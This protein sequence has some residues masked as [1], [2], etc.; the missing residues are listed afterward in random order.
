M[1]QLHFPRRQLGVGG[2]GAICPSLPCVR[3]LRA[4][5][6][7]VIGARV[8][9][10]A[11]VSKLRIPTWQDCSAAAVLG[12]VTVL[13][14]PL[15]CSGHKEAGGKGFWRT[16]EGPPGL[17][18]ATQRISGGRG[19][20]EGGQEAEGRD[21]TGWRCWEL[22]D[23]SGGFCT[24]GESPTEDEGPGGGRGASFLSLS[25]LWGLGRGGDKKD[26]PLNGS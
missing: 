21:R 8:C 3:A 9:S 17:A 24:W 20:A 16:E 7:C 10:G 14:F 4:P 26:K 5:R 23:A 1:R 6:W 25:L 11:H 2:E 19:R 18:W 12:R 15:A 22:M 13:V